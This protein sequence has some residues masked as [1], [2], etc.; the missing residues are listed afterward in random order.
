MYCMKHC[1]NCD[2]PN[3]LNVTAEREEKMAEEER[4]RLLSA[5]HTND[6]DDDADIKHSH[7]HSMSASADVASSIKDVHINEADQGSKA[8]SL[9]H[10]SSSA[11][12]S[13]RRV[14]SRDSDSDDE[15]VVGPPIPST[16]SDQPRPS[17]HMDSGGEIGPLASA[18]DSSQHNKQDTTEQCESSDEE[19][20]PPA[21]DAAAAAASDG[22]QDDIETL[23]DRQA[24]AA[25]DDGD[26]DDDDEDDDVNDE[27]TAC[28]C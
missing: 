13:H 14:V 26:D 8:A 5:S 12:R 24:A 7:S 4:E 16:N 28:T 1:G 6:D 2:K 23:E 17:R 3:A 15:D 27:V 19:I 18:A 9:F 11:S 10:R 22:K 25:V 20:G 21:P